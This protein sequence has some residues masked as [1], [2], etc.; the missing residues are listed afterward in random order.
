VVFR[1]ARHVVSE[2]QR[3]LEAAEAIQAGEW[4]RVGEL[5]Y[6][7]HAS[8]R[9]DY[10]VSCAELDALVEIAKSIPRK[11]GMIGCRMTGA[12][13]GGCAVSLVK[14]DAVKRIKRKFEEDYE[15][16]TRQ[17]ATIFSSRP[18][19]GAKVLKLADRRVKV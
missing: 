3:T 17:H 7:S 12:G 6:A 4:A 13:F 8:L 18:A 10:Q 14:T 9:D 2:N 16:A 1:R 19:G 11:E 5:M 15:K